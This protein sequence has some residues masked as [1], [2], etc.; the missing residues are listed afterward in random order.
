MNPEKE[1]EREFKMR[2]YRFYKC[3]RGPEGCVYLLRV[4]RA[5]VVTCQWMN[6]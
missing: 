6:I 1:K 3:C 4:L 5:A 2:I